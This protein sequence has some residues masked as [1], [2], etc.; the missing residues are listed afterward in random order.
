MVKPFS[1]YTVYRATSC[2]SKALPTH[3][4]QYKKFNQNPQSQIKVCIFKNETH[5]QKYLMGNSSGKDLLPSGAVF[6]SE[7]SYRHHLCLVL[8]LFKAIN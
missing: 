6:T 2:S 3:V 5:N 1:T 7:Y 8:V 4:V